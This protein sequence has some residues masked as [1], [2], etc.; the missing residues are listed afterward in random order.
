MVALKI[1]A[2]LSRMRCLWLARLP[3]L[4]V[5]LSLVL[6]L[7]SVAAWASSLTN[8]SSSFSLTNPN[9]WP[10]IPVPEIVTDPYA[11]T[12]VGVMP[13]FLQVNSSQQIQQIFAPDVNYST[14]LGWGATLRY[15]AYP[16]A[17]SQWYAIAGGSAA[18]ESSFEVDYARGMQR[19]Q[20]WSLEGHFL[21]QRNPTQRFFGL[22]NSTAT[23]TQT[24]YALLQVYGD[25]IAGFNLTPHWQIALRERPRFVRIYHGAIDTLPY[26]GVLFPN[27]KGLNGGSE[28]LNELV[29]SYDT[30]NALEI[31]TQG[32]LIALF[33]GV[34]DRALFSSSSYSEFIGDFRRYLSIT[35]RITLAGQLYARYLPAGNEAPFWAM[36]WLGGDGPGESSLLGLPVSD[37]QTFRGGGNG[38]Y[39]DNNL[40]L[41]NVEV[42]TRVFELELFRTRGI[43]ELTPF[44]DL[45]R[46]FH[47]PST[48]PIT[49]LHPA[50]GI[51]IRAIAL[52]FV[53][54]Y[55][56]VGVGGNG[57]A[58]FSGIN[59]PF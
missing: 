45:G 50:G 33:A 25:G 28:L 59:Y 34:S 11:G 21:Y 39:I 30:R 36:S 5:T 15:L 27:L 8:L 46:V 2:I 17:D 13:V 49:N 53:V 12:M 31:P 16:S 44:L 24:N 18:N 23:T 26:T 42:R 56:D 58:I 43:L 29:A 40:F 51:G 48:I 1:A 22:G 55:V 32:G 47:D 52:P 7:G 10:F 20:R 54:A 4:A 37:W 35:K 14:V 6:V 57:S 3:V 41:A 19:T 9:S 38:R